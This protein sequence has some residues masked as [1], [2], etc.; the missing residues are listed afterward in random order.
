[1]RN[2]SARI[3]A[4]GEAKQAALKPKAGTRKASPPRAAISST[5]ARV[6]NGEKP[7]PWIRNRKMLTSAS[8]K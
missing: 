4:A 8:R 7:M 3:Q 1:M 5:P 6:A 2:A